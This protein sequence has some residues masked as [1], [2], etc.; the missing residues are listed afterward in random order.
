MRQ[1]Y[2]KLV[3]KTLVSYEYHYGVSFGQ[4]LKIAYFRLIF[5]QF[6]LMKSQNQNPMV[7]SVNF[8]DENLIFGIW[9]PYIQRQLE[10][11]DW[12]TFW[13]KPYWGQ[14]KTFFKKWKSASF[15]SSH[16]MS[17]YSWDNMFSSRSDQGIEPKQFSQ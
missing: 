7:H 5:G 3:D 16:E 9:F 15:D 2:P 1:L 12:V 13:G 14:Q 8:W 4:I 10:L 17:I 6:P 11:S